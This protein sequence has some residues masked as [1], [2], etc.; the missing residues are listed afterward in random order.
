MISY[1]ID[2]QGYL[3]VSREVVSE[4]IASFDYSPK[5]EYF[6]CHTH[7]HLRRPPAS[8]TRMA[9]RSL[10]VAAAE[11]LE[12]SLGSRL[13]CTH[14]RTHALHSTYRCLQAEPLL[15]AQASPWS[16]QVRGA[17]HRLQ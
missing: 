4:D 13:R 11:R 8:A 17:V 2:G 15:S 9:D 3:I 10:P 5:P 16:V 7:S 12:H 1:M 6:A 14:A